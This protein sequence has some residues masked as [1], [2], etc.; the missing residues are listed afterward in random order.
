MKEDREKNKEEAKF[1]ST[2]NS[3]RILVVGLTSDSHRE[4]RCE[5]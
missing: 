4:E 1:K 3:C 2:S 5:I